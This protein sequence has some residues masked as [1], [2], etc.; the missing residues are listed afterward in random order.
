MPRKSLEQRQQEYASMETPHDGF[1]GF[2]ERLNRLIDMT[3][4]NAPSL[5]R[6][7]GV[8]LAQLTQSSKAAA[9]DW[10]KKDRLP[11]ALTLRFMISHF[12]DHLP[13]IVHDPLKIECWVVYGDFQQT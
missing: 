8:W 12:A 6:G 7:R 9:S 2:S 11:K 10:L 5:N 4:L 1:P 13:P 3:D